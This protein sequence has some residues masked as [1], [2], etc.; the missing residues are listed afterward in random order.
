[1]RWGDTGK[2]RRRAV[3]GKFDPHRVAGALRGIIFRQAGSQLY[4]PR[5]F[6]MGGASGEA[7]FHG[8]AQ[9]AR[10][11]F[12]LLEAFRGEDTV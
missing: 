11:C 6:Q 10:L 3:L 1:M 2:F 5:L 4:S 12:S 7:L 9:Q 8:Q